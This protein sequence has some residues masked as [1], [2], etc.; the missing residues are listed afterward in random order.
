MN[1]A[2]SSSDINLAL[3]GSCLIMFTFML[4]DG[5]REKA[6]KKSLV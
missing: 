6:R 1:I 2:L 5:E 4:N 3:S